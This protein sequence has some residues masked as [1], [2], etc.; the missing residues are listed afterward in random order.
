MLA[1]RLEVQTES[2]LRLPHPRFCEPTG[3]RALAPRPWQAGGSEWVFNF[4]GLTRALH[5]TG[6]CLFEGTSS[7]MDDSPLLGTILRAK[8]CK[9]D[10]S[11]G[12]ERSAFVNR[13]FVCFASSARLKICLS[14]RSCNQLCGCTAKRDFSMASLALQQLTSFGKNQYC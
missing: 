1:S 8:G 13:P 9:D 6:W 5:V 2:L 12:R 7:W 14:L 11:C 4:T 10:L 3:M